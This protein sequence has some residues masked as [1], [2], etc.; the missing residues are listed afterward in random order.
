MAETNSIIIPP[1][2]KDLTGQR[3]GRLLVICY[4][5]LTDRH[6]AKWV[7]KC[8]CG[9]EKT[10]TSMCLMTGSRSCGCLGKEVFLKRITTH[11]KHKSPEYVA[12]AQ[13]K[14]RC[15][16][17]NSSEYTNYGGR[18]IKVC[19]Q[20]RKSFEAFYA[21]MGPRPSAAHSLDRR[22]NH[23]DYCSENC[24]WTTWKIQNRNK[25]NN[26]MITFRDETLCLMDW[27]IR[28]GINYQTLHYRLRQG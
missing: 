28:L 5:G 1:R 23:A 21:D 19:D 16:N 15:Y 26:R 3:F 27:S 18:G 17:S 14:Q 22:D 8:D 6:K 4:A 25:R 7:C 11:G 24:R 9:N 13:M 12:W 2:V 20:W 10:V